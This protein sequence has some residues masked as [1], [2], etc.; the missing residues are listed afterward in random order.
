V[1]KN[2]LARSTFRELGCT[3][4]Q[5]RLTTNPRPHDRLVLLSGGKSI[6]VTLGSFL[7][8]ELLNRYWAVHP[9]SITSSLPVTNED[10]SEARYRTP[11]ATSSGSPYR[12]SGMRETMYS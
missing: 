10:S 12:P 7:C 5:V 1:G 6:H 8:G 3:D 9:P 2:S 4:G 11:K